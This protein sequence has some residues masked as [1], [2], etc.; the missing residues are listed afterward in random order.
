[1]KFGCPGHES[2]RKGLSGCGVNTVQASVGTWFSVNFTVSDFNT[3]PATSSVQRLILVVS[4]CADQE[5]YCPDL[6]LPVHTTSQYACGTT[7]CASRAATLALQ[8]EGEI[9]PAPTVEFSEAVP[10]SA[11]YTPPPGTSATSVP[12]AGHQFTSFSQARSHTSY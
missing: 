1:M 12:I 2:V 8:P 6:A 3:P 11:V 9:I 10:V 5:T 7:D 4:P